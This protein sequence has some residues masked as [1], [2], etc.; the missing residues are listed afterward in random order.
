MRSFRITIDAVESITYSVFVF[1]ILVIQHAELMSRIIL[2][3]VACLAVPSSSTFIVI[4]IVLLNTKCT[5][6]FLYNFFWNISQFKK[7]LE[8]YYHECV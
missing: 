4:I 1:V 3:S 7:N 5:F 2:S 8:R 6:G